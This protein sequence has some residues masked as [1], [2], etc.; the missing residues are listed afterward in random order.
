MLFVVVVVVAFEGAAVA[1]AVAVALAVAV[2]VLGGEGEGVG[3]AVDTALFGAAGALTVGA[4]FRFIIINFR[5]TKQRRKQLDD[6]TIERATGGVEGV[7]VV[8]VCVAVAFVVVG[9][10]LPPELDGDRGFVVG[11][12]S[13]NNRLYFILKIRDCNFLLEFGEVVGDEEVVVVFDVED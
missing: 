1:V 6:C 11:E 12:S 10:T 13:I 9:A 3:F 5:T 2:V 8:A 4:R 7:V